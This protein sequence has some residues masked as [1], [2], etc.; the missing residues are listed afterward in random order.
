MEDVLL[1]V[2]RIIQIIVAVNIYNF[3]INCSID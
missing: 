1:V 2:L 3:Q